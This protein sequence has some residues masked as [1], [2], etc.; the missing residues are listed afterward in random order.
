M[1]RV[2]GVCLLR[3][4]RA[5]QK[6]ANS[7]L[8]QMDEPYSHFC[9]IL[10]GEVKLTGR[11][12]MHKVCETGETLLEEVL[13]PPEG[14]QKAAVALEKARVLEDSWILEVEVEQLRKLEK[15]L[16]K[17]GFRQGLNEMRTLIKRNSIVK[18]WLRNKFK[19]LQKK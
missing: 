14:K 2:I 11:F 1:Q 12:G 7:L 16:N 13:D 4:G 18:N 15:E 19:L 17:F 10:Q 8:Y 9:I 5:R 6:L 3:L